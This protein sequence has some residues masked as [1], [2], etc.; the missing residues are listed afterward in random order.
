[1]L[2][3]FDC[4]LLIGF[5]F[6]VS[7]LCPSGLANADGSLVAVGCLGDGTS[8]RIITNTSYFTIFDNHCSVHSVVL[9]LL[10]VRFKVTCA[11]VLLFC[12]CPGVCGCIPVF[13]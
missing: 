10:F 11:L 9:A 12:A 6:N 2:V 1:M 4:G 8:Y 7:C 13:L 3:R 5:I